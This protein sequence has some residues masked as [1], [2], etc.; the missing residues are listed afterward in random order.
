MG[1]MLFMLFFWFQAP[2]LSWT[3]ARVS[4]RNQHQKVIELLHGNKI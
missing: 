3:V 1:E 4:S 2:F